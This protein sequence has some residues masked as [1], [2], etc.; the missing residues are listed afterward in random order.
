MFYK[1]LRAHNCTLVL[2]HT[3]TYMI[4]ASNSTTLLTLTPSHFIAIPNL[5]VYCTLYVMLIVL[6]SK[7]K[8]LN[9]SHNT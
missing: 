8:N 2:Y 7:D 1:I 3:F 6:K 5:T 9:H 4:S